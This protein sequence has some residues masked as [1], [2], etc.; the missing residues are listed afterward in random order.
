LLELLVDEA[1]LEDARENLY[2]K[3]GSTRVVSSVTIYD[4]VQNPRLDTSGWVC[5]QCR[6]D[7]FRL[8]HEDSVLFGD[9]GLLDD[10][11]TVYDEME[12]VARISE[13]NE[14]FEAKGCRARLVY[15][16]D[17]YCRMQI[18]VDDD[19]LEPVA[20]L[21]EAERLKG[22]CRHKMPFSVVH[23]SSLSYF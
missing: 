11:L 1:A 2:F 10:N 7:M 16:D 12:I 20:A 3:C 4:A 18:T 23:V 5:K 8:D 6:D 17:F 13:F 19:Q 9:E 15:D 21:K 22:L 14:R